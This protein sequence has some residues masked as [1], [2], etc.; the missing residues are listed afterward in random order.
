MNTHNLEQ[1]PSQQKSHLTRT[2]NN[3]PDR[4]ENTAST[5]T[6]L[7]Q[8]KRRSISR[9]KHSSKE[10]HAHTQSI[11]FRDTCIQQKKR[12]FILQ[13]RHIH[14][15]KLLQQP[16][17]EFGSRRHKELTT[18]RNNET[19]AQRIDFEKAQS[20]NDRSTLESLHDICDTFSAPFPIKIHCKKTLNA[21]LAEKFI[22]PQDYVTRIERVDF[23]NP[24]KSEK[25]SGSKIS[26]K[27]NIFFQF[28]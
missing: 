13:N 23:E 26:T 9:K 3:E 17:T 6:N 27:F 7:K 15:S 22:A 8:P 28:F 4:V 25:R 10:S 24:K 14:V 5:S 20:L 19:R 2:Y 16:K 21:S 11:H 18:I 12:G 1:N